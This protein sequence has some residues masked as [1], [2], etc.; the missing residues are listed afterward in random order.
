ME[1]GY[2]VCQC[3][4]KNN[5]AISVNNFDFDFTITKMHQTKLAAVS[6]AAEMCDVR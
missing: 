5:L 6:S 1:M 3:C 2:D 4:Q